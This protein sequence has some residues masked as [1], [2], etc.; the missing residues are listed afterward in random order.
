MGHFTDSEIGEVKREAAA[1]QEKESGS[2]RE[3]TNPY[4]IVVTLQTVC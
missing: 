3:G 2:I 1:Q 4:T